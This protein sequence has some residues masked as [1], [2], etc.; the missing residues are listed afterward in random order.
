MYILPQIAQ[1]TQRNAASCIISQTKTGCLRLRL[2]FV[3]WFIVWGLSAIICGISGRYWG[4]IYANRL[5]TL[6]CYSP[7]DGAEDA[8]ECSKLHYHAEKDRL[9]LV[10]LGVLL[11]CCSSAI[12]CEICGRLLGFFCASTKEETQETVAARM[13]QTVTVSH[14][15]AS[16]ATTKI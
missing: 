11:F 4:F 16:Q 12:I 1:I 15:V 13:Q 3:L 9:E 8:D 6:A 5:S 10:W 2:F 7:A 14:F